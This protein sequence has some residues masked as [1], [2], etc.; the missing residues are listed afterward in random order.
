MTRSGPTPGGFL[1]SDTSRV[2]FPLSGLDGPLAVATRTLGFVLAVGSSRNGFAEALKCFH[3]RESFPTDYDRFE[4]D[5]V[6]DA[7]G[8]PPPKSGRMNS[9]GKMLRG[10]FAKSD[11]SFVAERDRHDRPLAGT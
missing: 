8:C 11:E 6:S 7:R 10:C 1:F 2:Q 4:H 5:S 3:G 9:T